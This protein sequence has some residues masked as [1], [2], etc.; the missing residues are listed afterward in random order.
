LKRSYIRA[1]NKLCNL[2]SSIVGFQH[3]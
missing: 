1:A 2:T 3:G